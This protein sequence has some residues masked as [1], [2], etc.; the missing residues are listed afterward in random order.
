[1]FCG[2]GWRTGGLF[3]PEFFYSPVPY[4]ALIH[5]T[6][7]FQKRGC[8]RKLLD[9]VIQYLKNWGFSVIYTSSQVDEP[10]PQA[11]YRQIEFE[12]RGINYRINQGGIG[13]GFLP[14]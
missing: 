6:D 5:G 8:S 12:E 2:A 13:E 7:T 14:K 4:I 3:T 10:E 11:W 9:F 1:M